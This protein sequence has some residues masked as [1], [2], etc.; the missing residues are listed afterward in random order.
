ME[1]PPNSLYALGI[2]V[3]GQHQMRY[4]VLFPSLTNHFRPMKA[5]QTP[6]RPLPD[7]CRLPNLTRS[8]TLCLVAPFPPSADY[9]PGFGDSIE[10]VAKGANCGL[11]LSRLQPLKSC[12]L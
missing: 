6:A 3:K 2:S 10:A 12:E 11:S 4:S 1:G 5:L 8:I 9:A 7:P